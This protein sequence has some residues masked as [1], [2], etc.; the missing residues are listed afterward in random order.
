MEQRSSAKGI[1]RRGTV[2]AGL[3]MLGATLGLAVEA[4]QAAGRGRRRKNV[5]RNKSRAKSVGIGG[6]GGAGG[7]GGD[8]CIP[9]PCPD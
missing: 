3:S 9:G 4:S 7:D 6:P 8:V 5:T 2:V 1:S